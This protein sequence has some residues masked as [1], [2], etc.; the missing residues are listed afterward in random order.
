LGLGP[1]VDFC[2]GWVVYDKMP[3]SLVKFPPATFGPLNLPSQQHRSIPEVVE[4]IVLTPGKGFLPRVRFQIENVHI[5]SRMKGP[6]DYQWGETLSVEKEDTCDEIG[7]LAH[8]ELDDIEF[9]IDPINYRAQLDI[10]LLR[11]EKIIGILPSTNPLAGFE[12]SDLG[13]VWT[14]ALNCSITLVI[15]P[16]ESIFCKL[17]NRKM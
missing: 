12:R 17:L 3:T 9:C 13:W 8:V 2:K 7:N 6:L 5:N 1:S 14:H 16:G 4:T 11:D 10:T 15:F